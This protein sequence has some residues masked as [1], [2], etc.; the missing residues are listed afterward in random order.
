MHN[1]LPYTPQARAFSKTL[2]KNM[3]V[4]ERKLWNRI[5]GKQYT[6]QFLRQ[7][8][9]LDYVVDFYA[10]EIGLAIEVDGNSHDNRMLEDSFRQG[11][12]EKLGVKFIRFT[13]EQIENNINTVLDELS[14]TIESYLE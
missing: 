7:F 10:K 8:P 2:R 3:T 14:E 9:I 13:N 5:K 1:I 4:S 6:V 12:I 11:R